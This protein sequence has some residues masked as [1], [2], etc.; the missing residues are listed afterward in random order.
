MENSK[1]SILDSFHV[2]RG[3]NKTNIFHDGKRRKRKANFFHDT[4]KIQKFRFSRR[5]CKTNIF[6]DARKIQKFWFSIVF[7]CIEEE[8]RRIFFIMLEKET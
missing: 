7:T 5:K 2:R 8:I 3:G 6:N 1:I 4:W